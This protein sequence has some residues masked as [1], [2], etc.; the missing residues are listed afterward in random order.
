MG[1]FNPKDIVVNNSFI[2]NVLIRD[3]S[4]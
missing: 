1:I 2:D 4:T 3:F